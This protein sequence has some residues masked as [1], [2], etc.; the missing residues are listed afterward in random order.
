MSKTKGKAMYQ[1][2]NEHSYYC[3]PYKCVTQFINSFEKQIHVLDR[4]IDILDNC[5]GG[6]I[7]D[8][9]IIQEMPFPFVLKKYGFNNIDTI[10]IREDSLADKK[11]DF[12]KNELL[13]KYDLIISN[14][15]FVDAE[16]FIVKSIEENLKDDGYL[17]YLLRMNFLASGKRKPFWNKY[18]AKYMFVFQNRPSFTGGGTDG[19]DYAMFVWHKDGTKR[20]SIKR[21]YLI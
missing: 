15:P 13:K 3:T 7:K 20:K 4:N 10:D 14:P 16:D 5:S 1:K 12:L 21:L 9:K 17:V 19:A 6:V 2:D 11:V 18:M 8:D